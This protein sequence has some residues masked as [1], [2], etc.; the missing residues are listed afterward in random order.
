MVD[1][2]DSPLVDIVESEDILLGMVGDGDDPVRLG[3]QEAFSLRGRVLAEVLRVDLVNHV[4][5]GENEWLF[6]Q[7]AE[8]VGMIISGM[9]YF[10]PPE[11]KGQCSEGTVE[12]LQ[13]KPPALEAVSGQERGFPKRARLREIPIV[14]QEKRQSRLKVLRSGKPGGD[15]VKIPGYASVV[16]EAENLI[17]EHDS[18]AG[19]MRTEAG[20]QRA[21]ALR[22][23]MSFSVRLCI[24]LDLH[25]KRLNFPIWS[26]IIAKP[27]WVAL[28]PRNCKRNPSP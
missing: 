15:L 2:L 6:P 26:E 5:D 14:G 17:I 16:L 4:V 23:C 22:A 1:D 18:G 9:E 13:Q 7:S 21:G 12:L 20:I 8:K 27:M 19:S 3:N 11:G 28:Q 24:R 25:L 10:E